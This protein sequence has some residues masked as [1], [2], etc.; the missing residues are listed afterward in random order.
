MANKGTPVYEHALALYNELGKSV[1]HIP[2]SP[3]KFEGSLVAV[4]RALAISQSYY[5]PLFHTLKELGCIEVLVAARGGGGR[6]SQ[7]LLHYPPDPDDFAAAWATRLTKTKVSPIMDLQLQIN[8]IERRLPDIDLT[9]WIL[10]IEQ[11]LH[12]LE[13]TLREVQRLGTAT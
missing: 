8:L 1:V 11:R 7:V 3:L 12:S 9:E 5:S 6:P 2:G 10:S 13:D 4:F